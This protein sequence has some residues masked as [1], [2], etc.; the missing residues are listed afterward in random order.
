MGQ[1]PMKD[2][3]ESPIKQQI[4]NKIEPTPEPLENHIQ[5]V[6]VEFVEKVVKTAKVLPQD[7]QINLEPAKPSKKKK[8]YPRKPKT[9]L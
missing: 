1:L 4:I 6:D 7:A 8:Y 2:L 9:H 3:L 5:A